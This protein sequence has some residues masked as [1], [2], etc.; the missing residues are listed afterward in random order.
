MVDK[1]EIGMVNCKVDNLVTVQNS[2]LTF[3]GQSYNEK[4]M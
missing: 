1:K 4:N 2:T 3:R